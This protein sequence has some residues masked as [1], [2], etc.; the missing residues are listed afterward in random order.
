MKAERLA[1]GMLRLPLPLPDFFKRK[2]STDNDHI[3]DDLDWNAIRLDGAENLRLKSIEERRALADAEMNG[4][5]DRYLPRRRPISLD[6]Y[7]WSQIQPEKVAPVL[8]KSAWF[9]NSVESNAQGAGANFISASRKGKVTWLEHFNI[10]A[11]EPEEIMHG[12]IF[13][14]WFIRSGIVSE[15]EIDTQIQKVR[16]RGITI[17][18]KFN[19]LEASTYGWPQET[20]GKYFY[21]TMIDYAKQSENGYDPVLVKIL[22]DVM[23]QENFHGYVQFMGTK[24]KLKY[25]PER[26]GKDVVHTLVNFQ[27]PGHQ[28]CPEL[29]AEAPQLAK[30]M[31]LPVDKLMRELRKGVIELA[32]KKGVT[33]VFLALG[34]KKVRDRLHF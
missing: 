24:A 13:R 9:V 26:F 1:P 22:T 31:G 2:S 30:E 10:E 8:R 25:F 23:S 12:Q 29:Q 5:L 21:R 7:D 20:I 11:W 33:Q 34:A 28:M 14:E 15:D 27:M 6:D 17:G 3:A 19:D 18:E 32:G 16:D 4:L